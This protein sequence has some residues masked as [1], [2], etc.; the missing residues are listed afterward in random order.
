MK[1]KMRSFLNHIHI[2]NVD[3]FDLDFEMVGRNRFN[4]EQ[5]DMIITKETRFIYF[6]S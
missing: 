4:Y 1:E 3:D 2:E 6:N 5:I